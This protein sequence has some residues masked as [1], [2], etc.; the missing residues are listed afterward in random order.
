MDVCVVCL[1]VVVVE[2]ISYNDSI[3][4]VLCGNVVN[5]LFYVVVLGSKIIRFDI[6]VGVEIVEINIGC[7]GVV[8]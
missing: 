6:G 5:Y 8:G 7:S 4:F 1:S 3:V 2:V